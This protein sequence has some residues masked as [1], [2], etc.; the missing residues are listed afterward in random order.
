MG[1]LT[2]ISLRQGIFLG[3][4]VTIALLFHV[5]GLLNWWIAVMIFGVFVLVELALEH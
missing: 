5:L 4:S 1:R 3:S 2:S